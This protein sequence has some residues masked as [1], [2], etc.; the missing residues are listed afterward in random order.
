MKE[1]FENTD[2][3]RLIQN[4][5][6][7]GAFITSLITL[8]TLFV[9]IRQR[10]DS[11]RPRVIFGD[12]LSAKCRVEDDNILKTKWDKAYPNKEE[13]VIDFCFELLNVGVGILRWRGSVTRANISIHI[14]NN[15]VTYE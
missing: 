3:D 5:S 7:L 11:F 13:K 14:A 8:F 10:K 1:Y 9:L 12:R 4:L 2:Y 15:K 6:G